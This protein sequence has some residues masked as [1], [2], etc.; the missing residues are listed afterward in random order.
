ML[1]VTKVN[2][3]FDIPMNRYV[4]KMTTSGIAANVSI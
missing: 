3:G 1:N 4:K 2:H